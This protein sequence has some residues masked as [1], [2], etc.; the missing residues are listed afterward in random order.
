MSAGKDYVTQPELPDVIGKLGH[1]VGVS[2]RHQDP[3]GVDN[4]LRI[5]IWYAVAA[6]LAA[7]FRRRPPRQSLKTGRAA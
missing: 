1:P 3:S 2:V 5:E 7:L 4:K 6:L